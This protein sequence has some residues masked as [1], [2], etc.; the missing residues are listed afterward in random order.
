MKISISRI[1]T[2]M[3]STDPDIIYF[4]LSASAFYITYNHR[5]NYYF[6]LYVAIN[7]TLFVIY[8]VS[9]LHS[10]LIANILGLT[11]L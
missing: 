9:M 10:D 7:L 4:R 6:A 2:N 3:T 1:M 5:F 11:T 8:I